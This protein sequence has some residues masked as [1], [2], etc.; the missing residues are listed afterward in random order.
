MFRLAETDMD[1]IGAYAVRAIVFM[2]EQSVSW[3]DEFDEYDAS[4]LH[5]LGMENGEPFACGRILIEGT[6]AQ[7]GRLAIRRKWRGRNHGA[8]LLDFMLSTAR[9]QG[10]TTFELHA[11]THAIGFY[12]RRGFIQQGEVFDEAGIQHVTMTL[13]D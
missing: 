11:Q 3:I 10:C 5:I 7:L 2:E 8:E 13:Q 6:T 12:A 4:A 9:S 1:R